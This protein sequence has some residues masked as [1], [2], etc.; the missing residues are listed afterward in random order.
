MAILFDK[1]KFSLQL[2]QTD[3]N[4][5]KLE[6]RRGITLFPTL[7]MLAYVM[8]YCVFIYFNYANDGYY[9]TFRLI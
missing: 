5:L 8:C 2:L 3:Y 9:S 1:E 6:H 4:V 7:Y